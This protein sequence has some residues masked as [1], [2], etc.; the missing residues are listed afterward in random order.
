MKLAIVVLSGSLW[1]M[2]SQEATSS[3]PAEDVCS[4]CFRALDESAPRGTSDEVINGMYLFG[5]SHKFHRE[6]LKLWIVT[7]MAEYGVAHTTCPYCRRP[8]I[9]PDFLRDRADAIT[10][11]LHATEQAL[12]QYQ[13][14]REQV[15]AQRNIRMLHCLSN[16]L[17]IVIIALF[18]SL[19]VGHWAQ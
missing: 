4:I 1:A 14:N 5:C 9:V 12:A 17:Y 19:F 7:N 13:Q 2:S 16:T 6:C 10:A 18:T 8:I 11:H 3:N 15:N